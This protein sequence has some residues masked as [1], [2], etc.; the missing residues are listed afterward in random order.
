MSRVLDEI[1]ITFADTPSMGL[2]E[3][4]QKVIQGIGQR[5][6]RRYPTLFDDDI[7]AENQI[8]TLTSDLS[9]ALDSSLNF[10]KGVYEY[11]SSFINAAKRIRFDPL[12]MRLFDKSCP[13]YLRTVKHN[14]DAY[15]E[16]EKFEKGPVM[17]E[18]VDK[19]IKRHSLQGMEVKP[20][21]NL[22]IFCVD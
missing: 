2:T 6:K 12:I 8:D 16:E 4:G 22:I 21:N 15:A 5:F 18:L 10:L 13:K 17:Q 1:E 20:S 14:K 9:Q 11:N 7:V 19:F 3:Q